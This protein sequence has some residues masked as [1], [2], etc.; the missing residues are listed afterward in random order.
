MRANERKLPATVVSLNMKLRMVEWI[1]SRFVQA[2][3]PLELIKKG[4]YDILL[5]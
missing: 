2:P 1:Y 4:R 5:G 3:S